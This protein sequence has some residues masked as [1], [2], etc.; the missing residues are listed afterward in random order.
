MD[1][2]FNTIWFDQIPKE[3]Q[4]HLNCKEDKLD[5][6]KFL[7]SEYSIIW[8]LKVKEKSF[9]RLPNSENLKFLEL[10]WANFKELNG[11]DKFPDLKRL[12]LHYC[13]KLETIAGIQQKSKTLQFLHINQSKKL[14]ID[15]RLF[16][17]KKLRV[18]CLN[19]CGEIENLDFLKEFPELIDFRF[20]DTKIISGDLSPILKHPKIRSVGFMNK[21]HYN[22]KDKELEEL[23]SKKSNNDYRD[24]I[25]KGEYMTFKYKNYEM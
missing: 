5:E 25:Y 14:K 15:K 9:D 6:S 16:E 22:F 21:R 20:V 17:L 18:L 12:E 8:H 1:W 2:R 11:L 19:S 3:N 13:T 10:N 23:L 4:Y 7:K 24:E